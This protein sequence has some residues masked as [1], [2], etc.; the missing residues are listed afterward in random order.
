MTPPPFKALLPKPSVPGH[1]K[2]SLPTKGSMC[3]EEAHYGEAGSV[4]PGEGEV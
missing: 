2:L 3:V 4:S 1:K